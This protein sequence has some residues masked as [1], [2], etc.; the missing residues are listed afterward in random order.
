MAFEVSAVAADAW[1]WWF[2]FIERTAGELLFC[3]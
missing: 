2:S 1:W 3:F